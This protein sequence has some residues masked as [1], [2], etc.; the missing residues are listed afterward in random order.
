MAGK[1]VRREQIARH[2]DV[3]GRW[4]I[5]A[6]RLA[7]ISAAV[8]GDLEHAARV[9]RRAGGGGS[10]PLRARRVRRTAAPAVRG[11]VRRSALTGRRALSALFA[12]AAPA[13]TATAA[14]RAPVAIVVTVAVSMSAVPAR[15]TTVRAWPRR[16]GG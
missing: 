2:V 5:V 15:T 6:Q 16:S 9:E 3:V 1:R 13:T 10:G 11:V 12:T 4:P 14:A 7:E 8:L